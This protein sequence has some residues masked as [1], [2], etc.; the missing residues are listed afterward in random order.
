[1]IG[2]DIT[3]VSRFK[4]VSQRFVQNVLHQDEIKEFDK[5]ESD[6]KPKFLATR[7]AI[8]EALF[9]ADNKYS[10]FN[11]VLIKKSSEGRYVFLDFE[12]STSD[13]GNLLIAIVLKK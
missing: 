10:C 13:E 12:I 3:R 5:L 7:W 1:M 8:K 6:Q 4:K 9:K 2:I 11:E